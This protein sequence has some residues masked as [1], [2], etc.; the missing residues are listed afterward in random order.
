MDTA[1]EG[2]T[3]EAT[4]R[5]ATTPE[6]VME[7]VNAPSFCSNDHILACVKSLQFISYKYINSFFSGYGG[8]QGGGYQGS[9]NNRRNNRGR[10][11]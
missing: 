7:E 2:A 11:W 10:G 1:R 4:V 3:E 8:Y 9:Y 6:G 5:A